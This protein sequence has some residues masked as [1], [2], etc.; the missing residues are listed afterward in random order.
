MFFFLASCAPTTEIPITLGEMPLVTRIDASVG[1]VYAPEVETRAVSKSLRLFGEPVVL[2]Q[3]EGSSVKMFKEAFTALFLS[4]KEL[5]DVKPSQGD[6]DGVL[7]LKTA[8]LYIE[9]GFAGIAGL[10][11]AP[12]VVLVTYNVCLSQAD[13]A[14]IKCWQ[15]ASDKSLE[16]AG[17][18]C[19]M[20]GDKS[21]CLAPLV[22]S[23]MR[24]ALAEFLLEF[25]EDPVVAAWAGK[26]GS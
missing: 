19:M 15:M 16:R 2:D 3:F 4:V 23:A 5:S 24:E 10:P 13:G 25:G 18:E 11:A 8:S 17:G 22:E 21:K 1:A 20:T 9:E 12:D 26:V 6:L 14:E 7:N